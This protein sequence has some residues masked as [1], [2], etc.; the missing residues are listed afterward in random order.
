MY[1]HPTFFARGEA[2]K[3]SPCHSP[4]DASGLARPAA[5]DKLAAAMRICNE[6]ERRVVVTGDRS[7]ATCRAF[8]DYV[9][10]TVQKL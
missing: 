5:A 1:P 4:Q 6:T 7:G 2:H 8:A 9:M 3:P 10:E